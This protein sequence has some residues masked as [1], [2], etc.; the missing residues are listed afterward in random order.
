M[1]ISNP[2]ILILSAIV[3]FSA[4]GV[5]WLCSQEPTPRRELTSTQW[6]QIVA[7]FEDDFPA[8]T[9]L[10]GVPTHRFEAALND[11]DI[12]WCQFRRGAI[13]VRTSYNLQAQPVNSM[14]ILMPSGYDS[15]RMQDHGGVPKTDVDF[16]IEFRFVESLNRRLIAE[17]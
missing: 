14:T 6:G 11:R 16:P 9:L 13:A 12:T 7:E 8:R 2:T 5:P 10:G 3:I 17:R 1:Q 4:A 15:P